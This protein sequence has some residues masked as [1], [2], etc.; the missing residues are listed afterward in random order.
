MTE[1]ADNSAAVQAQ[2][3]LEGVNQERETLGPSQKRLKED[4]TRVKTE[5]DALQRELSILRSIRADIRKNTAKLQ[6]HVQSLE[7]LQLQLRDQHNLSKKREKLALEIKRL[8]V[9]IIPC[10]IMM[11]RKQISLPEI[12]HLFALHRSKH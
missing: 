8:Q 4:M 7:N 6:N 2:E 3:R 1:V 9:R 12:L 5:Q 11:E 10:I